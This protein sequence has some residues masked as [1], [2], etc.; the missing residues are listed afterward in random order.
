[1]SIDSIQIPPEGEEREEE[2]DRGG[3]DVVHLMSLEKPNDDGFVV[4]NI[5]GYFF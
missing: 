3:R 2:N 1:M 4:G 5:A